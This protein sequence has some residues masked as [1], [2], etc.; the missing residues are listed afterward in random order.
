[1]KTDS[2]LRVSAGAVLTALIIAGCSTPMIDVTMDTAGEIKLTGVSK[3]ALA[4]FNSMPDD[5]FAGVMAADK[6]TCALVKR[7]VASAFYTSPMYQI[8]DLDIEKDIHDADNAKLVKKR[9]DAFVYGRLWWQ[10]APA[11]SGTYP[12]KLTLRSWTNVPYKQKDPIT[13]KD[14]PMVAKV[15]TETRDVIQM[16]DYNV[17]NATLMLTLSIYRVDHSGSVEKIV[18][19]YQ[20]TNDGFVLKNGEIKVDST[21][22][23]FNDKTAEERL[24]ETKKEGGM[25]AGI[26]DGLKDA[27]KKDEPKKDSRRDA[28][29]KLI[30]TQKTVAMP[31]ELQAKLMLAMSISQKLSAKLAPS[32]MTFQVPADIGDTRL[33]NLLKNGAYRSAKEY[34]L[35]M[36]RNKLGKQICGKVAEYIPALDEDCSYPV[37]DSEKQLAEYDDELVEA[38]RNGGLYFYTLGTAHGS[39]EQLAIKA[40][41]FDEMFKYLNSEGVDVYFYALGICQE[42][43]HELDA[44]E[45]SYRFAFNVNPSQDAALG[46]ARAR[47]ALGNSERVSETRKAKNA[48]AKKTTLD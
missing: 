10:L 33:S 17:Q 45:E 9:F 8:A 31:T 36:L 44:A 39:A 18:D 5:A 47:L 46:I 32:K 41:A 2:V 43:S 24:Q 11:A 28:N 34:S 29:G 13:K 37:P 42:T 26:G 6:E 1:M 40:K 7:A 38:M 35:Y 14:I 48:A 16:M 21:V 27:V 22:V 25:F 23:G 19:T 30:L 20:V 12:E 15:T 3:I 4:N